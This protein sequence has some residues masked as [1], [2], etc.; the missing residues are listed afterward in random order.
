M[1]LLQSCAAKGP[2]L[3]LGSHLFTSHH[4]DLNVVDKDTFMKIC[5]VLEK[6]DYV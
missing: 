1:P 4:V 2:S 5:K 6:H 3:F